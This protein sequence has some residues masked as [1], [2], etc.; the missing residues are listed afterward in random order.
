MRCR[1]QVTPSSR[2]LVYEIFV[3]EVHD[4]PLPTVWADLL[5]SVD[6]LKAF[7]AGRVGLRLVPD[8]PMSRAEH[9]RAAA[10]RSRARRR[11]RRL[12]LRPARHAGVGARQ[13]ALALGPM[14]ARFDGHRRAPRL[15]GEPYHFMSRVTRVDGAMG[16]DAAGHHREVAYD[17][18]P[19]AWYFGHGEDDAARA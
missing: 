14:Y 7:H 4:G 1:G 3:R 9:A 6:G 18:P 11:A 12:P 5:C 19:D 17:V 15:P 10:A 8:W 13:A 2:E 16:A